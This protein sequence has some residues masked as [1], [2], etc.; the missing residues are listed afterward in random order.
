[1]S[2]P[3]QTIVMLGATQSGKSTV[4]GHFLHINETFDAEEVE[5]AAGD[6]QKAGKGDSAKWSFLVD[7]QQLEREKGRSI[8]TTYHKLQTRKNL[9]T[10]I[11]TPGSTQYIKNCLAGVSVAHVG[12]VV[13]SAVEEEYERDLPVTKQHMTFAFCL[14]VKTL[15]ILI[16]KFDEASVN[17]NSDVY[18]KISTK[19]AE[20]AKLCGYK[21]SPT[22]IPVSGLNGDLLTKP[23]TDMPWY[24]GFTFL[25]AIEDVTPPVSLAD[26]PFRMNIQQVIRVKGK[27][28]VVG[29]VGTGS[30]KIG[31]KVVC[32]PGQIVSTVKSIQMYG[33][34]VKTAGCNDNVGVCL[35]GV[36]VSMV[37]V[38]SVLSLQHQEARPTASFVAQLQI[39]DGAP[40][41]IRVGYSAVMNIHSTQVSCRFHKMI[42]TLDPKTGKPDQMNPKAIKAGDIA[43]VELVPTSP[44]SLESYTDVPTHGRLALRNGATLIAVGVVKS[45]ERLG[46]NGQGDLNCIEQEEHE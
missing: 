39:R 28:V 11:D 22:I 32:S 42:H 8:H 14:G 20:E 35:E 10:L 34:D 26:K 16:N 27:T 7:V 1:M 18:K 43:W 41:A 17:Y 24:K 40:K 12:V 21:T 4:A 6:S 33:E 25:S 23:S 3:S 19:L 13:V 29:Q 45:V 36:D 2:T 9:Y 15:V 30:V 37:R 5:T 38:G 31:S 46:E 44:L